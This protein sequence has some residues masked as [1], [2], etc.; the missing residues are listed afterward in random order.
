MLTAP[1]SLPLLKP[2][3]SVAPRPPSGLV[4]WLFAGTLILILVPGARGGPDL[5]ATLPF[6]LIGAPLIGLAWT[7]RRAILRHVAGSAAGAGRPRRMARR[8]RRHRRARAASACRTERS[9]RT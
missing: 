5:G 7:H 6:W 4:A 3:A 2:E 8:D 1:L 9:Y